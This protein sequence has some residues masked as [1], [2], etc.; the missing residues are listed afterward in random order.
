[1]ENKQPRRM[2]MASHR[3]APMTRIISLSRI[4]DNGPSVVVT[5]AGVDEPREV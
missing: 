5:E 2:D 3:S 4:G 1:M